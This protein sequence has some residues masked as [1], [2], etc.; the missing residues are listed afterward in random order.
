MTGRVTHEILRDPI[1]RAKTEVIDPSQARRETD[2]AGTEQ[3]WSTPRNDRWGQRSSEEQ[4][5]IGRLT[6]K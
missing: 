2:E 6:A 3:A 5:G 4:R 1:D